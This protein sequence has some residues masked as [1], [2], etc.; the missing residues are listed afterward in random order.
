MENGKQIYIGVFRTGSD[1]YALTPAGLDWSG[2]NTFWDQESKSGKRLVEIKSYMSGSTRNFHGVF[3]SGSGGY[4]LSPYGKNYQQFLDEWD[5]NSKNGLRLTDV[6]HFIDN[7]QRIFLGSYVAGNDGYAL[8]HGNDF[9]SL[10]SK[11]AELGADNL[12]LVD[13]ET[14]DSSCPSKCLNQVLMRD[15]PSTPY[16][17]GYDYGITASQYHCTGTPDTCPSTP[18][19]NSY[20]T[21]SWPNLKVGS[22][23]YMR[24]SVI[25]DA[26]DQIFQLPF[27]EPS[28]SMGHNGWLYSAGN[29]HHAIDYSKTGMT[30]F[31]VRAAA[32]GRVIHIGWDLWSGNTM[33]LSHDVGAKKDAYRTIYMHLR[34]GASHDCDSAWT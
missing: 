17:D 13:L 11:W 5:S 31:K 28:S 22:D 20:V 12:R 9:E 33:V 6:E 15:D 24:N 26:K 30:T 19:A 27:N 21:Y 29:W 1:A 18:A 8:W 16:R 7:G 32:A 14:Y 25:F 34:N 10:S 23:Y 4:W 2:F 3:R